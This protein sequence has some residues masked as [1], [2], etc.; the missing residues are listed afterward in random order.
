[1]K[2]FMIN[3]SGGLQALFASTPAQ[4]PPKREWRLDQSR[5]AQCERELAEIEV[6]YKASRAS[7]HRER[8]RLATRWGKVRENLEAARRGYHL[9]T[10]VQR[11]TDA[12]DRYRGELLDDLVAQALAEELESKLAL[13]PIGWPE[14]QDPQWYIDAIRWGSGSRHDRYREEMCA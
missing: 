5:I 6:M 8:A 12:V 11:P 10:L 14:R 7:S 3:L 4:Q 2:C 9:A 1:M 13:E